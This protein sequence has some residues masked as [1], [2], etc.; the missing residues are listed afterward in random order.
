MRYKPVPE[1]RSLEAVGEIQA[2][3]PLVPES[4]EDCCVRLQER[5][6]VPDR[7]SAREWLPFLVA[8]ELADER[9]GSYYRERR[10]PDRERLAANYEER[11]YGVRETMGALRRRESA[12]AGE[13]FE[14]TAEI[15]PQWERNRRPEW[16]AA[17][18]ERT[19]RVLEWGTILGLLTETEDRYTASTGGE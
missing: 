17:W 10:D 11:V 2:A 4:T 7:D 6:A 9:D 3:L 14:A 1:P 13:L 5:T 16:E 18:R 12:T 15:V 8:L 19:G